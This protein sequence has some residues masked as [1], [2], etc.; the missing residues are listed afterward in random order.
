MEELMI[1][2]TKE[3]DKFDDDISVKLYKRTYGYEIEL[4]IEYCFKKKFNKLTQQI[5]DFLKKYINDDEI[6]YNAISRVKFSIFGSE[7][8]RYVKI[9]MNKDK[10]KSGYKE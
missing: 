3:L 4:T 5:D 7:Y 2:I 10:R 8:F 6:E 9:I 1:E